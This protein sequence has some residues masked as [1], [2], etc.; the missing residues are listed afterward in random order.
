VRGGDSQGP[1]FIVL[2][3]IDHFCCYGHRMVFWSVALC[4]GGLLGPV[5]QSDGLKLSAA[6]LA[7]SGVCILTGRLHRTNVKVLNTEVPSTYNV[8]RGMGGCTPI[9][10]LHGFDS[11]CLEFRHLAPLL[12][13]GAGNDPN[14]TRTVYAPDILGWG[15]GDYSTAVDFSPQSKIQHLK[16]FIEQV[17]Q[18]PCILVGASLGGGVAIN[19]ATEVCPEL[20]SKLVLIDPQV[21]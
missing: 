6:R 16:A 2:L 17:V 11:N 21:R 19:L 1:T 12:H 10:L 13:N 4:L 20:V 14:N 18:E 5:L 8:I 7:D 15:F 3:L 9:V